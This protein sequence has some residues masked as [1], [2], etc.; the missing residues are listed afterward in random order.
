[1][2]VDDN[3]HSLKSI[4]KALDRNGH[5]TLQYN[6]AQAALADF[7][8]DTFSI[9]ITDY[10]MPFMNGIQLIKALRNDYPELPAIIY[11]GIPDEMIISEIRSIDAIAFCKPLDFSDIIETIEF[12]NVKMVENK[13]KEE[14]C[15]LQKAVSKWQP[16]VQMK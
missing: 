2:L 15:L 3:I 4:G 1:M 9:V 13:N 6:N 16:A 11:T 12:I 10:N 14:K 5:P 8:P 7:E